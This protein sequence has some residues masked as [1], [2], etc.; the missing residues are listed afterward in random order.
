LEDGAAERG[1]G[2]MQRKAVV[3]MFAD[4]MPAAFSSLRSK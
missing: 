1:L 3:S 4:D 2:A